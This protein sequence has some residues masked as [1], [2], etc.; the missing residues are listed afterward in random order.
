MIVV[1]ENNTNQ[2]YTVHLGGCTR[3]ETATATELP[4]V[5]DF[6]HWKGNRR[7]GNNR[8]YNAFEATCY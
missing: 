6:I 2:Q 1:K 8:H 3:L 4:E 5:G 7:E